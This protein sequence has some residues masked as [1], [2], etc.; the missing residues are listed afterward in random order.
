[1]NATNDTTKLIS[2]NVSVRGQLARWV[3]CIG[4]VRGRMSATSATY[5]QHAKPYAATASAITLTIRSLSTL[6]MVAHPMN[7]APKVTPVGRECA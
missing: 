2:P 4:S 6:K 1:M 5:T 7:T 3:S